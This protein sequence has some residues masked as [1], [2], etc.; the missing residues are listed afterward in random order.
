[1]QEVFTVGIVFGMISWVVWVIATNIRQGHVAGNV[2]RLHS[3]LLDKCASNQDL[4]SYLESGPGRRFLESSATSGANPSGRILN[5]V[6]AG[7]IFTLVGGAILIA[8][9]GM[10]VGFDE[11]QSLLLIGSIA[12]AVGIGFLI[13]AAVSYV[14]CKSWGL[15]RS[16]EVRR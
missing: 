12:L 3:Q 11:R 14:L 6:Q 13:S 4:L 5:A 8:H 7:A 16:A 15:L 9:R 2:A 10:T 1:M